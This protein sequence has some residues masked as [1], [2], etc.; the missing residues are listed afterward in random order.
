MGSQYSQFPAVIKPQQITVVVPSSTIAKAAAPVPHPMRPQPHFPQ[1]QNVSAA[2]MMVPPQVPSSAAT[3]CLCAPAEMMMGFPQSSGMSMMMGSTMMMPAPSQN[4]QAYVPQQQQQAQHAPVGV[5]SHKDLSGSA[6]RYVRFTPLDTTSAAAP[7]RDRAS[8][9]FQAPVMPPVINEALMASPD[10]ANLV[11]VF[12][13]QLPFDLPL[14]ALRALA[15]AV[16]PGAPIRIAHAAPHQRRNGAYDG[17]CFVKMPEA[18]AHRFIAALHK[19]VLFDVFGLWVAD[20][21]EGLEEMT[22]YC[23]HM[24]AMR[25]EARRRV[26]CRP[27]PFSAVTAELAKRV[28]AF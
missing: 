3:S 18:D 16:V 6:L 7:R 17:C 1:Q 24:Q 2:A 13:S 12:V 4:L 8:G 23:A 21:A 10:A 15:D 14:Q 5:I 19:R 11:D 9:P 20:C 26:L 28:Y 25:P 22:A 27:T